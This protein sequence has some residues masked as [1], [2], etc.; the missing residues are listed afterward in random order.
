MHN[1]DFI[2]LEK[3][4]RKSIFVTD[5]VEEGVE[6]LSVDLRLELLLAFR[7]RNEVDFDVRVRDAADVHRGKVASLQ[8]KEK[9]EEFRTGCGGLTVTYNTLQ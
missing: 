3:K 8:G 5:L 9:R 2:S 7:F 4:G 1:F 6:R